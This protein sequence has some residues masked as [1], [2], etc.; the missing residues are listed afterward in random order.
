[1]LSNFDLGR[2]K[3]AYKGCKNVSRVARETGFARKTIRA[4]VKRN[5]KPAQRQRRVAPKI[6]KRRVI[7]RRLAGLVAQKGHR[8]W[9]KYPSATHLRAALAEQSGEV[10]NVRQVQRELHAIGLKPYKRQPAATKSRVDIAKKKAFAKKNVRVEWKRIVFSDESWLCC[11]ERTGKIHWTRSRD[12]VLSLERKARWN[13]PSVMVWG[14]VGWNFKSDLVFFPSKTV[15]NGVATS[16]RLDS[17]MYVRRCLSTV[18][19]Q[20]VEGKRIFQHDGARSHASLHTRG[21]LQRSGITLLEDWPP[22]SPEMNVIERIWKELKARVGARCPMTPEELIAVTKEEW[23][24]LPQDVI[25]RH[26]AL[27]PKQL[28]ACRNL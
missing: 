10:L 28:A 18:K 17:K 21:Y 3:Q 27:F 14:A 15:V 8:K 11:N 25:N 6:L 2:I 7:L 9:P 16:F 19:K 20:L 23:E 5:F 4:A 22:Y 12:Q 24:R 1:M 13:V 26:C